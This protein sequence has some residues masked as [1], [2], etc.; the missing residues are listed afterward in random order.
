M[1]LLI[2]R[3]MGYW[4]EDSYVD[5]V[6]RTDCFQVYRLQCLDFDDVEEVDESMSS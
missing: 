3:S 5:A 1:L 6:R 4:P 2:S